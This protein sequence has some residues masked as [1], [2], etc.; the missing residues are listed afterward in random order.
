MLLTPRADRMLTTYMSREFL[1][2]GDLLALGEKDL[3]RLVP[4]W[5]HP[6]SFYLAVREKD[7]ALAGIHAPLFSHYSGQEIASPTKAV[8]SYLETR[9]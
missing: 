3:G 4:T 5:F 2:C 8:A 9:G 6:S 1:T 7:T